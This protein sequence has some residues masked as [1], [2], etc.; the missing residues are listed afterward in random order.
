MQSLVRAVRLDSCVGKC[1]K[2]CALRSRRHARLVRQSDSVT[3]GLAE[4]GR[5][6]NWLK[7]LMAC[8]WCDLQSTDFND[9]Q[10]WWSTWSV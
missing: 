7:E 10:S 4:S 6:V 9:L 8:S 1:A 3:F 2:L 5:D